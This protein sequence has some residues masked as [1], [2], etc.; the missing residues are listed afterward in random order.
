MDVCIDVAPEITSGRGLYILI[1]D[2]Q[3]TLLLRVS[4]GCL[5]FFISAPSHADNPGAARMSPQEARL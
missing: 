5:Y 2:I 1:Y 3:E 4:G